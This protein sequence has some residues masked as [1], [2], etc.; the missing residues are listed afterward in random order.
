MSM[1]RRRAMALLGGV[2]LVGLPRLA[3][4]GGRSGRELYLGANAAEDGQYRVAGITPD[5]AKAFEMILHGRAH[6]FA[7][8]PG[9]REA[10]AFARRPGTFAIVFDPANGAR[11]ARL[12][13]PRGWHFY[14][15]GAF[16]ADGRY[17]Y[18]AENDYDGERGVIGIWDAAESYR[19]AGEWPSHGI[20]PH[21]LLLSPD[22]RALIVANGGILTHPETGRRQLNIGTMAPSLA[23]I[24]PADG[25]LLAR[26]GFENPRHRLLSI[27]HLAVNAAGVVCIGLQDHGARGETMPLVAFH[28]PGEARL[29]LRTVPHPLGRRLRGYMGA[30][31]MDP[32]GR[33]AA[34][35]APRGNAI[36][37]WDV[38]R[39]EFL[40][41]VVLR[42]GCGVAPAAGGHGGFLA[43][44]GAGGALLADP[45]AGS[46][47]PV[48][49]AFVTR[50]RW[51]NHLLTLDL[52]V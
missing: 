45:G 49:G 23:Y 40:S 26:H 29:D 38:G 37:F 27:R 50:R 42:D 43:T 10:V 22:G 14:G 15:H 18:S 9:R 47:A 28:G 17:L 20:G 48:G 19:R 31:A 46:T 34:V 16:S 3:I 11:R 8:R 1:D 12:A 5:G 52:G 25:S 39:R 35:S 44:S 2:S 21:E 51:D 24:D 32:A 36:T 41:A 7:A 30:V 13:S 33:Y 4:A 6:G